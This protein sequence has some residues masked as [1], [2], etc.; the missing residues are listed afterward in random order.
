[1]TSPG[2]KEVGR[3]SIR[4][5][6]DTSR[7]RADL[8]RQL[9]VIEKEVQATINVDVELDTAGAKEHLRLLMA[10]LKAQA[11]GGINVD[12]DVS[13]G[14]AENLTSLTKGITGVGTSAAEAGAGIS[15]M[16]AI[17][18][19][20]VAVAAP[21]V[22]LVAGLLAGLPSILSA[23]GAGATAVILGMDGIKKAAADTG[24]FNVDDKTGE[25]SLGKGFDSIKKQVSETFENGLKPAFQQIVDMMPSLTTGFQSVA[26]GLSTLVQGI[27]G[28]ISGGVGLQNIQ[29][30]LTQ[31]GSFFAGLGPIIATG[32]Q[33]FLQLSSSGASAFNLLLAPLQTF[34]T[35]FNDMVTR[36]TSNGS[37]NSAMQGMSVV[38]DSVLSLFNRLFESGI[39]AM[40]QLGGPIATLINGFSDAFIA[41][42]PALT[43]F[44]ALIGNVLGTALTAIAPSITALTPAFTTLATTLGT[45]LTSNLQ[46]LAPILTQIASAIGTS[47][48]TALTAI[49][50]LLPGLTTAFASFATTIATQLP[51]VLPQMAT[52][53]GALA[54][55]LLSIAPSVLEALANAFVQLAPSMT[56][57]APLI[58]GIATAM[59]SFLTA[60]TPLI[61]DIVT[62]A[63]QALKLA[64]AFI[65]LAPAILGVVAPITALIGLVVTAGEKFVEF[66]VKAVGEIVALPGKIT[67]AAGNFGSILIGAGKAIMDGLLNGIKSGFEA[68]KGFVSTIAG[69]IA[70]LKGPLPYDKKVL[71]PNGQ[72]LM[73]GLQDGIEGGFQG[74]IDRA[75]ALAGEISDAIAAGGPIDAS[76]LNDQL[77]QQMSE[78]GLESDQLKVQLNGTDD[79]AGKTA[80]R[81]Q[82]TQLQTIKDQLNLQQDQLGYSQK[83]GDSLD[84][85]KNTMAD[86]L[87]K[88]VDAGKGFAESNIKQFAS[89]IGI[90]GSGAIP[91]LADQ[92]V[93]F[94]MSMLSKLISGGLGQTNIN[95]GS[96]DD[97]MAAK[98]TL[99]NKKALQ[100]TQR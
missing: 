31:T 88:I 67:A 62:L 64:P 14:M 13:R 72:A 19:A 84:T 89:D 43:Q 75:K 87:N 50:P 18:A 6:P 2:G 23:F 80:I 16:G 85:N 86:S 60:I 71:T 65:Q 29:N 76:A 42:M 82:R 68:V 37:F 49:G 61:P 21:A 59:T 8:Q 4:V 69:T 73:E 20:V 39:T 9:D 70:S 25:A 3:I 28:V 1:M 7:F 92:G 54:G 93:S 53:F 52:A 55:A 5:V 32:T 11:A 91:Q 96:V 58:P 17:I 46:S 26:G 45:L 66:G 22:G 48:N 74:V 98:Q 94:G 34:A 100:Y 33:A 41:A 10:E 57:I 40:G 30:I 90:S 24:L 78:I 38:L 99:A 35:G 77:K 83:Y 51:T 63:A 95:V 15:R 79:K 47:L 12:V 44:S 97:A 56:T 81:D 36:I 27:T